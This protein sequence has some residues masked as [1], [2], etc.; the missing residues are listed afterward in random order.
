M[1]LRRLDELEAGAEEVA[2]VELCGQ[3]AFLAELC[4]NQV[5]GSM[6]SNRSNKRE[7]LLKEGSR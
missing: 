5:A 4:G 3:D 6:E 2:E 7:P 1:N